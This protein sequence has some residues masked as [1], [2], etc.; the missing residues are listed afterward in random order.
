MVTTTEA[1]AGRAWLQLLKQRPGGRGYNDFA[2]VIPGRACIPPWTRSP[3]KRNPLIPHARALTITGLKR[4][5]KPQEWYIA[6][7]MRLPQG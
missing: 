4:R 6:A 5:G 7:T 2:A 1:E 3:W